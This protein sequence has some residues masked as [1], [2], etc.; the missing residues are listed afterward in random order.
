[1]NDVIEVRQPAIVSP[2]A[3]AG[4]GD[5]PSPA[6]DP[7]VDEVCRILARVLMRLL[8]PDQ[9]GRATPQEKAA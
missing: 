6:A 5:P 3:A 7:S 2:D 8:N 9:A 4:R 1:M